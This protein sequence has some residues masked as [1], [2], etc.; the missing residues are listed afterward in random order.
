MQCERQ[1]LMVVLSF[2]TNTLPDLSACKAKSTYTRH[3]EALTSHG[4]ISA[5]HLAPQCHKRL[6]S[7]CVISVSCTKM[8]QIFNQPQ[9]VLK[10][11]FSNTLA[12]TLQLK[13]T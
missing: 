11:N 5:A 10:T 1:T 2:S 9:H 3:E 12:I 4:F 8:L 7:I 13:N 6:Y